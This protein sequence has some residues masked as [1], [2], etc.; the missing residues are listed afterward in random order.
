[1]RRNVRFL[2]VACGWAWMAPGATWGIAGDSPPRKGGGP[3]VPAAVDDLR[4]VVQ[5]FF[6]KYCASCHGPDKPKGGLNLET[7]RDEATFQSRRKSWQRIREYVEGGIMP[8]DES[9]QPARAE[10]DRLTAS[11]K[12]ALDRDD[13]GKPA[14]SGPRHH[15][16]P[17][18]RRVQ[19]HDPRPLRRGLPAR[20]RIPDG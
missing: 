3:P 12:A 18:S 9:P 16:P 5:P 11:I 10:V 1:M 15:P 7:L 4:G 13:C 2:L 8:P 17:Q 6:T 20:R 14:Q 19:Q